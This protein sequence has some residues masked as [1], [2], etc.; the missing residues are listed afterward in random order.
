MSLY[1]DLGLDRTV[2][3]AMVRAP[4]W[5]NMD[6][7]PTDGRIERGVDVPRMLDREGNERY[8]LAAAPPKARRARRFAPDSIP[9]GVNLNLPC[10]IKDCEECSR[11]RRGAE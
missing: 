2:R 11:I 6:G 5:G 10:S 8:M 7:K 3:V 9:A 1:S 4:S